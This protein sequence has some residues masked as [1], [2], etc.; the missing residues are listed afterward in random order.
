M[1]ERT[2][3]CLKGSECEAQSHE[4]FEVRAG[5]H[6]SQRASPEQYGT[7]NQLSCGK[8]DQEVCSKWL[9]NKLGK[10]QNGTEPGVLASVEV[11]IARD[12]K[13]RDIRQRRF[14]Q[15]LEEIRSQE[16][17]Q[18]TVV[19][20]L[21]NVLLFLIGEAW[22]LVDLAQESSGFVFLFDW[23]ERDD[24]FRVGNGIFG[25]IHRRDA[26]LLNERHAGKDNAVA[27]PRLALR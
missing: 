1:T 15:L 4:A 5:G 8:F 13:H 16:K 20:S 22:V 6:N 23:R 12:T 14:V 3:H 21:Q 7:S 24:G 17:R 18:D 27:Q 2:D 19:N 10:I 9:H 11:G 26:G 25:I